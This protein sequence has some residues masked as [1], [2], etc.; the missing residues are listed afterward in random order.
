MKKFPEFACSAANRITDDVQTKAGMEG[1]L[2]EGAD[3]VQIIVWQNEK[4]GVSPEATHPF[5]EYALVVEGVYDG[6]IGDKKIHLEPGDE[7]VI[8]PGVK[9]RGSYSAG[10]RAIDMFGGPRIVR[11]K[12]HRAK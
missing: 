1:Y 5:W 4:G 10:Y 11:P 7:A 3:G 12:K 6:W 8:P 9:H 2:F